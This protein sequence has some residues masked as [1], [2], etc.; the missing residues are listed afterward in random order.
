VH[1]LD[2]DQPKTTKELLD[3]ATHHAFGEEAIGAVFIQG[4]GETLTVARGHHSRLP[5]KALREAPMAVRSDKSDITNRSQL[6]LAVMMMTM[7][8][9]RT[10]PLRNMS[11]PLSAISSTK[12]GSLPITSRSFSR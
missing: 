3:I 10:T 6:L 9:R 1:E 5:A 12:R 2:H 4:N 8:R 7:A 11:L